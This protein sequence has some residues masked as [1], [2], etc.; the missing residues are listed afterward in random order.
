LPGTPKYALKMGIGR[1]RCSHV[2]Q[3]V[4]FVIPEWEEEI[5]S[6]SKMSLVAGELGVS[7][8]LTALT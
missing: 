5:A 8:V 3:L 6:S 1:R 4:S 7:I 2:R